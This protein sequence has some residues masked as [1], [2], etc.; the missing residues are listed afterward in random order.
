VRPLL[1]RLGC[2]FGPD[3]LVENLSLAQQQLV[4][5]VKALSYATRPR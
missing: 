4:E 3:T 1:A 2:D 5:I